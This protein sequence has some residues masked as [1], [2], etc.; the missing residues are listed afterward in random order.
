MTVIDAP[1][2]AP[3]P[4]HFPARMTDGY[5]VFRGSR[6]REEKERYR[7]LAE[8]GQKP[9]VMLIGCCDSRVAPEAIFDMAPGEIFVVRNVANLVPPFK[10]DGEL[11]GTSAALEFAVV[12][13]KV[14]HI[15][16]MGHGRCGGIRA[17][18]H[19]DNE[20]LTTSNFIGKWVSLLD[21]PAEKIR[22]DHTILPG[23]RYRALEHESIRTSIR[24]LMTFP[25]IQ[26]RFAKGSLRLHG[27]WFDVSEGELH[28]L[29]QT[30]GR[31]DPVS[32]G[33]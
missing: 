18:L 33:E 2:R 23:L 10:P 31:F 28:I 24:N 9:E 30:T 14:R 4:E 7:R 20:P 25:C 1:R 26:Q 32:D 3:L 8:S 17:A 5:R 29:D 11:H 22:C 21:E 12:A 6:Y 13:L 27:A 16:V 15:V 19:E